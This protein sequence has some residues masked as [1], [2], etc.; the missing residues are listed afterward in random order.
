MDVYV[1]TLSTISMRFGVSK[2]RDQTAWRG[3]SLTI[4]LVHVSHET[5]HSL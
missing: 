3:K 2:A 1:D 5:L 4:Y